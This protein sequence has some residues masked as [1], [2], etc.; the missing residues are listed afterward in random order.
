MNSVPTTV[1]EERLRAQGYGLIAGIDEVGRGPLA[2]PVVAAA[3]ILAQYFLSLVLL[4]VCRYG[5]RT[6]AADEYDMV[7]LTL[8]PA[9]ALLTVL[10]GLAGNYFYRWRF[11]TTAILLGTVLATL[12]IPIM[13]FLDP[14]WKFNPEE[15]NLHWELIGPIVLTMIA[16]LILTAVAVAAAT[17]LGLVMTLIICSIVFLLGAMV[18]QLLG[19]VAAQSEIVVFRYLAHAG[20]A[21]VPSINIFVVT[22]AIYES[23][24]IPLNYLGQTAIY[25]LFYVTAALLFAIALF[26]NREIG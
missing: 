3:V 25:A 5:V 18:H 8:G 14:A 15:N 16:T 24:S 19:P 7:V 2:G 20:L 26:R 10:V 23:Q 9:A 13:Y 4:I 17:R 1:E 21:M 22:K 12:L 6:R 11:S